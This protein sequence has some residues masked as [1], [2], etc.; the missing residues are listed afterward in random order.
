MGEPD[1]NTI[2]VSP[3]TMVRIIWGFGLLGLVTIT[4]VVSVVFA[5]DPDQALVS[6][7]WVPLVVASGLLAVMVPAAY[8]VRN[9]IYKSHWE[10]DAVTPEGYLRG[11]FVFMAML[12]LPVLAGV[13]AIF[14]TASVWPTVVPVVAAAGAGLANF[15]TGEPMNP[16]APRLG[17]GE[18]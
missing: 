2:D 14:L 9:Q 8:F 3:L 11:N 15:P 4:A 10:G 5:G 17:V 13:A 12:E 16:A 1:D 7:S 18:K 6:D